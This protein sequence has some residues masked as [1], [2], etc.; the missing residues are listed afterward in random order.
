[1]IY[2]RQGTCNWCGLC[3]GRA[4][5]DTDV[6][7]NPWPENLS[8]NMRTWANW[9]DMLI[10]WGYFQFVGAYP[11][12]ADG[13]VRPQYFT[14]NKRMPSGPYQNTRIRW[15]FDP[16]WHKPNS[17]ECP[18]LMEYSGNPDQQYPCCLVGSE[19]DAIWQTLCNA[20][21]PDELN[22]NQHSHWI[23]SYGEGGVGPSGGIGCVFTWVE[24][25]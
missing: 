14:G 25:P 9:D 2:Q 5:P 15:E 24:V 19:F 18:C 11:R 21:P 16:G 13:K 23:A 1:M 7:E 22:D 20:Q 12:D 3:C 6:A 10:S 17:A 8:W 4:H